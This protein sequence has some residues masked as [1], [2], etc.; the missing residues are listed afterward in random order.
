MYLNHIEREYI[1][2]GAEGIDNGMLKLFLLLY[3][4]D[5]ILFANDKQNLQLSL[6]ILKNY[7]KR[8]KLKGNTKKQR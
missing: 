2:K 6:N 3:A 1:L 4:D 7:C 8:W 5:I